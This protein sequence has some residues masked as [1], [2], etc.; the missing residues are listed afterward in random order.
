MIRLPV[1]L[2]GLLIAEL[3]MAWTCQRSDQPVEQYVLD[4]YEISDIVFKGRSR[5][6]YG[7]WVEVDTV[8]KGLV[9]PLVAVTRI[10]KRSET[11]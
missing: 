2:V 6:G 8:W 5:A 1:L 4:G 10:T 7:T 9:P 11:A 3:A